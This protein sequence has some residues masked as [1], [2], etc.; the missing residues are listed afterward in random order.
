MAARASLL[1][2]II[3]SLTILSLFSLSASLPTES[4]LNAVETLSNA[5]YVVM[6]LT[7]QV[8]SEAVLTSQCRSAT[9]FAPPDYS[10]SR[11]GQPSLSL[12]RYHF[13]P[14][15]LSVDSLKSL[16]YG[17]KIPTLSAGKS[18]TVTS[19]ASDDRISLNDVKLSRWPIYDDGSL[20]IFGIESFLNPEFTS[21]IQIRNPSFD[22]GCVVVNDYPNT[23]SKGFMFGEASETL[24]ARGYSVMAAF[25]DLQLLG[26]IGQPKLTV[27]APV[28]EVMV[29]RAGDIPDYP[30]LFLRHVVP[31]KLSWIDMV[32]VN[33]GTELQTYLEG[34][35]MNVTRSSDLFMVNGV[36]ITFP[37]MYYSD[38]LVVHGLPEILPVPSTPEHE[39]SDPDDNKTDDKFPKASIATSKPKS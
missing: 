20:V 12:L 13:S 36:Q 10:F 8:S 26:F 23:L 25:L 11:S 7:L 2:L 21:T 3:L 33:Q 32:N 19:F 1:Q 4:I 31:C 37:D 6:S 14:L 18:L 22:V 38:W 30:S 15:A 16:P 24:R 9:V 39:G 27:F 34:F 5:G 17:T 28:D 35:G 29:N